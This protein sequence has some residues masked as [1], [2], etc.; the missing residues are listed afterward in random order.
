MYFL[1]SKRHPK[2]NRRYHGYN[3]MYLSAQSILNVL[4]WPHIPL[5]IA[6]TTTGGE[7]SQYDLR[8]D[9]E[10]HG[11]RVIECSVS[12]SQNMLRV[13]SFGDTQIATLHNMA[14][15]KLPEFIDR[16]HYYSVVSRNQYHEIMVYKVPRDL[17]TLFEQ[18]GSRD[19]VC[20][21]CYIM[22]PSDG[23]N[24]YLIPELVRVIVMLMCDAF[25]QLDY[26]TYCRELT[27]A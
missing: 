10:V 18:V 20:S 16:T 15:I 14:L 12:K 21:A 7:C 17:P 3:T 22:C 2:L 5:L 27:S 25:R 9:F 8:F 23:L 24:K 11:M 26:R 13:D 6:G 4:Y 1:P 19:L